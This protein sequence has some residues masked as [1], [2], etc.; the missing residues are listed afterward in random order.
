VFARSV[1]RPLRVAAGCLAALCAAQIETHAA[2]AGRE[3][4]APRASAGGRL[5]WVFSDDLDLIGDLWA[6]LPLTPAAGGDI[7]L[8]IDTRT[9]I[10]RALSSFAFALDDLLYDVEV[11]W[12]A[13]RS[14][15]ALGFA[16]SAGQ[17]G[18]ERVDADGQPWVRWIGATLRNTDGPLLGAHDQ[19]HA[20]ALA[21]WVTAGVA[22][23]EREVSADAV[24]RGAARARLW[25][26]LVLDARLDGLVDGTHL[27]ADFEIGPALDCELTGARRVGFFL[28]YL[29][30]ENPLG[31]GSS[32]LLLGFEYEGDT[33][34]RVSAVEQ[35]PAI[36]GVVGTGGGED[37]RLAAQLLLR[38]TSPRFFSSLHAIARVD[39]NIL[40]AKDTGDLYYFWEVGLERPLDGSVAG[41][42]AYH[43]SNHELAEPNDRVTSMNVIDL[44]ISTPDADR[45]G[46]RR[47]RSRRGTLEGA[48]H[49]G[50]VLDSSFGEDRHWHVRG[51]A[52]WSL[53]PRGDRFGP[54]LRAE[55]EAGDADRYAVAVGASVTAACDLEIQFRSD[56]QYASRDR[57]AFLALARYAF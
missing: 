52:R 46:L 42:Y 56:E 17:R 32:G 39:A 15:G 49:A 35:P 9:T 21:G 47:P 29:H 40:T 4:N 53:R 6:D 34:G 18:R 31:A 19:D 45:P 28:R 14:P 36:D 26:R 41:I 12:R 11:G 7:V 1:G 5:M 13:R 20:P 8:G 25:R 51:S 22:V 44:G 16:V 33:A 50:Y 10:E 43:R 23:E 2:A 37:G 3:A 38:F 27:A 24:L 48:A 30:A 57:D 54:Y 55:A